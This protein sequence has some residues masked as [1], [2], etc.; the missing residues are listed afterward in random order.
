MLNYYI[1]RVLKNPVLF[2]MHLTF[3]NDV[4]VYA[5]YDQCM[6]GVYTTYEYN[7]FYFEIESHGYN[8]IIEPPLYG[9]YWHTTVIDSRDISDI[10]P[11]KVCILSKLPGYQPIANII[12]I[13]NAR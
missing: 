6:F 8:L 4:I 3:R 10:H 11:H 12:Q 9:K 1:N 7:E 13:R 2:K 5:H